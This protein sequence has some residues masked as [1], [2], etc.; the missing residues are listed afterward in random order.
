MEAQNATALALA[1]ALAGCSQVEQVYY[2]G[3]PSDPSHVRAS[4]WFSGHGGLLSLRV[5]GGVPAAERLLS[6]LAYARVAPSLGGVETFA[7]RPVTT[8]H[9]GLSLELRR[10][11]GVPEDLVRVAVGL[12]DSDDLIDD[13]RRALS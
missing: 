11:M 7:S 8:S 1:T 9:A 6:R 3:L 10:A 12:E 2:T 4:R 5:R 13:F